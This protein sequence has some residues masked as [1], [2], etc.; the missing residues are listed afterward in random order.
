MLKLLGL[1][2]PHI[3]LISFP[4]ESQQD[5]FI[6]ARLLELRNWETIKTRSRTISVI[7]PHCA[8]IYLHVFQ[9]EINPFMCEHHLNSF[10]RI[11]PCSFTLSNFPK[12]E[13]WVLICKNFNE[14]V[15]FTFCVVNYLIQIFVQY[16]RR[17]YSTLCVFARFEEFDVIWM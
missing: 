1:Q 4:Y 9:Q 12:D 11:R 10:I 8:L 14:I 3:G 6:D 7:Q 13:Y 17:N 15:T 16:V 2:T 5:K